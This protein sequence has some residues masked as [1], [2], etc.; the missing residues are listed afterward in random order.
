[1]DTAV[2]DAPFGQLRLI[3][4]RDRLSGIDFLLEHT[5]AKKPA[6]PVLRETAAQ[7][8]AYFKDPYFRFDLPMRLDGTSF[9]MKV[10]HALCEI[11]SGAPLTYGELARKL[12]AAP[13]AVGGACGSNPIPVV[14]PCHRVVSSSGLGGFMHTRNDGPL[15]IKSWLLAHERIE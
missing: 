11:P 6:T 3:A 12:G 13:R 10:W 4:E 2:I 9:Q 15:K 5:P 8:A 7:L 14:I 1:M